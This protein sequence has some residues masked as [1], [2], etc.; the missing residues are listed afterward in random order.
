MNCSTSCLNFIPTFLNQSFG[1]AKVGDTPICRGKA[2]HRTGQLFL[3]ARRTVPRQG[4]A[5]AHY[6]EQEMALHGAT[7]TEIKQQAG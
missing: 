6:M 4:A 5:A 7:P 3:S 1:T 2:P